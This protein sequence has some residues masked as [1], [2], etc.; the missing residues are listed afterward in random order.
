MTIEGMFLTV[1][2]ISTVL[3]LMIFGLDERFNKENVTKVFLFSLT[4]LVNTA[5]VFRAFISWFKND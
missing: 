2:L 3:T 4:P 1:W 5:F